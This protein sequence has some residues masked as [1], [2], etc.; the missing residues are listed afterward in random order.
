MGK[1]VNETSAQEREGNVSYRLPLKWWELL[2]YVLIFVLALAFNSMQ[3]PKWVVVPLVLAILLVRAVRILLA[4]RKRD[5]VD[6]AC[7]Q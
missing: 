4:K 7:E 3:F 6:K 2:S 5:R 1:S